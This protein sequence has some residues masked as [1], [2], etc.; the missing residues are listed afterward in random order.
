MIISRD[1][2]DLLIFEIRSLC[3]MNDA[4]QKTIIIKTFYESFEEPYLE[5]CVQALLES[6]AY[7]EEKVQELRDQIKDDNSIKRNTE[8]LDLR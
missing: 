6:Q 2:C 4:Q 3:T 5:L 7:Y 8:V 1:Q